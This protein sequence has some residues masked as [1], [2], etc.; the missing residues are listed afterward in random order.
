MKKEAA[1]PSEPERLMERIQETQTGEPAKKDGTPSV[2]P[3][4]KRPA[5][6]FLCCLH[7]RFGN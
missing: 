7:Y 2:R 3:C 6:Y 5:P 1:A 4:A